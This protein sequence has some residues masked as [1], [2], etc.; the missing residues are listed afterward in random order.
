VR[1][2]TEVR[3]NW[4]HDPLKEGCL[5]DLVRFNDATDSEIHNLEN[6]DVLMEIAARKRM[7][8]SECDDNIHL[9]ERMIRKTVELARGGQ[10]NLLEVHSVLDSKKTYLRLINQQQTE[11]GKIDYRKLFRRWSNW[12]DDYATQKQKTKEMEAR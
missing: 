7:S 10:R 12:I 2:V 3:K 1:S 5:V 11:T 9:R 6:S 8:R 4:D